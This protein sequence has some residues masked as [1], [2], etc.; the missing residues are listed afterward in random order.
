MTTSKSRV[1]GTSSYYP[2]SNIHELRHI[3]TIENWITNAVKCP[4]TFKEMRR[5]RKN[6]FIVT[7]LFYAYFLCSCGWQC[8]FPTCPMMQKNREQ[9]GRPCNYVLYVF[10]CKQGSINQIIQGLCVFIPCVNC[11]TCAPK[12]VAPTPDRQW[13]L[14]ASRSKLRQQRRYIK[15]TYTSYPF[16]FYQN[17]K[18]E[19]LSKLILLTCQ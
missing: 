10:C 1:V 18:N 12:L 14:Q 16:I 2:V 13:K 8:F 3:Q 9:K 11:H 6:I 4:N 7:R 17:L 5:E 15:L 19:I